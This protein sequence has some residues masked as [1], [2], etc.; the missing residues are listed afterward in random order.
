MGDALKP[1]LAA[2][3]VFM[4]LAGIGYA[5][6]EAHPESSYKQFSSITQKLPRNISSLGIFVHNVTRP[7][8][9]ALPYLIVKLATRFRRSMASKV[10]AAIPYTLMV[11]NG[12][13]AGMAVS[14]ASHYILPKLVASCTPGSLES[15]IASLL[16]LVPHGVL[17]V[18]GLALLISAPMALELGVGVRVLAMVVLGVILLAVAAVVE[19]HLTP[20]I[21]AITAPIICGS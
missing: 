8:L 13:I 2:L 4:A 7:L 19:V 6:G 10:A 15:I 3:M 5:Y 1:F 18:S 16:L 11:V 17:E 14:V 12:F 9:F 21:F 20:L